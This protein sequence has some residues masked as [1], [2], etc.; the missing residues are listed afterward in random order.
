MVHSLFTSCSF[1]GRLHERVEANKKH[2]GAVPPLT[3]FWGSW[4][5][6]GRL[7]GCRLRMLMLIEVNAVKSASLHSPA[8]YPGL[9]F[10][11]LFPWHPLRAKYVSKSCAMVPHICTMWAGS[12]KPGAT[13]Q[14][15]CEGPGCAHATGHELQFRNHGLQEST[16]RGS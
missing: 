16:W 1:L 13:G 6:L 14:E 12:H 15:P 3:P 10:S 2:T 11:N 5:S 4:E 9:C 7:M 8:L